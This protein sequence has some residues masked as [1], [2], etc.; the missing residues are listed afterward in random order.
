MKTDF[1]KTLKN[2]YKPSAKKVSFADVPSMQYLMIDGKGD[3]GT[4][5]AFKEAIE[6][7]LPSCLHYKVY[8]QRVQ[9][10]A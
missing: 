8:D 1:K 4:S 3:P 9:S 7:I 2:L 5:K 6:T 10:R